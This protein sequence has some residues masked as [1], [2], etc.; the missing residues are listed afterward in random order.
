MI[1]SFTLKTGKPDRP[2][3]IYYRFHLGNNIYFKYST[4]EKIAKNMWNSGESRPEGVNSREKKYSVNKS[5]WNQ[6]ERYPVYLEELIDESKRTGEILD[7]ASLKTKFDK[8]FKVVKSNK[9]ILKSNTVFFNTFDEYIFE[10]EELDAYAKG[11]IKRYKVLKNLLIDFQKDKKYPLSFP[12]INDTFYIQ[13]ISYSRKDRKHQDNTVGR[14]MKGLKSFMNWALK[15]GVHEN[16]SFKNFKTPSAPTINVALSEKELLDFFNFDFSD[17]KRLDKV[18]DIFCF[19][20]FTGLRFSDYSTISNN[21]IQDDLIVIL[22]KKTKQKL[23]IPLNYYSKKIL[24]KY[25]YNMPILSNQKFN[26]YIKEACEVAGYTDEVMQVKY[27]GSNR[28]ENT[29]KKFELVSSHTARRTFA[30][31]AMSK[32]ANPFAV[33]Q[34]TGHKSINTFMRYVNITQNQTRQL[35]TDIFGNPETE[36]KVV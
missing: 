28:E 13:F 5:I 26:D 15:K 24:E 12:T 33:M 23:E 31:I 29:F 17:K 27:R 20:A 34:I 1:G 36:M 22:V 9:L 19:G 3:I 25:D 30:T 14:D 4:G 7:R 11:T 8:R 18:R 32:G 2:A 16:T 6:L 21:N 10:K 35:M